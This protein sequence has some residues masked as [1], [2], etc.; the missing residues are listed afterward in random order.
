MTKLKISVSERERNFCEDESHAIVD[1]HK[2]VVQVN[3]VEDQKPLDK[4]KLS[5]LVKQIGKSLIVIELGGLKLDNESIGIIANC[6][7]N[8]EC[9]R[10]YDCIGLNDEC[11]KLIGICFLNSQSFTFQ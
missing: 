3:D 9:I 1:N 6:G 10:I 2:E 8:I 11:L 5:D 7:A 4:T